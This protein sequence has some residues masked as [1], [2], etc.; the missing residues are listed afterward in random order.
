[1]T[2]NDVRSAIT[3]IGAI[4]DTQDPLKFQKIGKKR[5]YESRHAVQNP[6]RSAGMLNSLYFLREMQNE[7]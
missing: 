6:E 5:N 7:R 4:L 2:Q 1:M 3:S